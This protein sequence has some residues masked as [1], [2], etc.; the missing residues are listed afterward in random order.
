MP[1]PGESAAVVVNHDAGDALGN[2]VGSLRAEGVEHVVVVDNASTD[3]SLDALVASDP[4]V[5]V[6]RA[7][8]NLGYG[9]GVNL[10][11]ARVE[12][13]TVVVS[14]PDIV[15]HSGAISRLREALV[16]DPM[17]AIVGPRIDEPDG[18]RYPSARRFP[19]LVDAAGHVLIGQLFP[20]NRFTRRYRMESLDARTTSEVDWVSGAFFMATRRALEDLGGFDEGYFMYAEDVDLC[21]RARRSGWTVAYVPEAAVTHLRGVSTSKHPYKMIFEHH[22]SAFRFARR[23]SRGWRRA[24]L[25]LAFVLLGVRFAVACG[26][27]TLRRVPGGPATVHEGVVGSGLG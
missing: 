1:A 15:V 7:R 5:D 10:G 6:V 8:V 3:G 4:A 16:S 20:D 17:R 23:T 26:R 13:E 22:R 25:P 9:A 21:W 14:N 18:T 11:L 19:S 12:S 2:C 24:S 27:E